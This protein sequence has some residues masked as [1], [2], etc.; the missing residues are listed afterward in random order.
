M[1]NVFHKQQI[2]FSD[3]SCHKSENRWGR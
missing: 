1:K 2:L 3:V